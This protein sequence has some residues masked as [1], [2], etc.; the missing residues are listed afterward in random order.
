M[1]PEIITEF[2][3]L[4][5]PR[6][7]AH[8][9]AS[10]DYPENTL[11]AF[12]AAR[13]AGSLYIELDVRLTRDGVVVVAHDDGLARVGNSSRSIS[14]MTVTELAQVDAGYNFAP[15]SSPDGAFP[16]RGRGIHVPALQ[17]V[18]AACPTQRF[19][20][21]IKQSSPSLVEPLLAVIDRAAMRR[22]VLVACE[23]QAPIDEFRRA[24]P[25]IPTNFPTEEVAA[26]L[27]SMPP[28]APQ[29]TPR[30]DALQIPPEHLGWKIVTPE[31]VAAAHRMGLEL[32]IWT[33]NEP[34]A[35]RSLLA[36]GVDGIITDFPARLFKLLAGSPAL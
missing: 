13:D 21:E 27:M 36:L 35:M 18:F 32:H 22:R 31:I 8:R 10:G 24:A 29:F 17:E 1:R 33:V 7:I 28:G 6:V 4:P 3:D 20:V 26:F 9:G 12:T 30:G 14:E 2:F 19:I 15:T 25:D 23:H 11:A 5:R 34:A 16:F